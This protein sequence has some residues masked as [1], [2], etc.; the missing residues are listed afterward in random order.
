MS[1]GPRSRCSR[2]QILEIL[3]GEGAVEAELMAERLDVFARGAV[4][5]HQQCRV[6]GEA[7]DE[8]HQRD[9][10]EDR[11]GGLQ[12]APEKKEAHRDDLAAILA[13]QKDGAAAPPAGATAAARLCT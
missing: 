6:A 10:A 2:F 1:E 9:G 4:G 8:E 5:E 12:D 11:H 7:L 13:G 3:D